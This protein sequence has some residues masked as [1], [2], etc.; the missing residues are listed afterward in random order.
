MFFLHSSITLIKKNVINQNFKAQG[1]FAREV[2]SSNI[3]FHSR[4]IAPAGPM[5]LKRL[6]EVI[7]KPNPRS[8]KWVSTSVPKSEWN[9]LKARLCS[10]EY[11]TN[12][13]LNPVLFNET[14]SQIPA[15]A[16][17]IEIAPHG[18]LQA[19]LKR[20]LPESAINIALTR[21]G[22]PDNLELLL[23]AL[24]KMYNVGLQPQ[25]SNLYPK[26]QYPV[27]RGTPSISSLVKW[28]HSTDW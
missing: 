3:A 22:H 14:A 20:S 17:C 21:R 9:T 19:I 26:I 28:D 1:I 18:L 27:G 11:H 5:L 25:I 6:Q 12:N 16:V 8:V 13:L 23:G 15:N 24:G 10:A 7:P 2:P 4:Y